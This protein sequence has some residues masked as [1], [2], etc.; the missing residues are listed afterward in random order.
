MTSGPDAAPHDPRQ[1]LDTTPPTPPPP[2]DRLA[3]FSTDKSVLVLSAL[4]VGIGVVAAFVAYALLWLLAVFTNLAY[5]QRF[6]STFT[7]PSGN[8]L[9]AWAILVPA[10]GGLLIGLMAR[11]GSEMIRGH[12]IPEALEAILIGGS[13]VQP[14]VA[15]LKPLSSGLS[16]GTGGPIIMTGGALV[17]L[18]AQRV[19]LSSAERKTLLVAGAAAGMAAIFASPM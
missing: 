7:S 14:K 6:S 3:D 17:S 16:I 2:H 18:V 10:V 4:A 1:T 19:H 11:Y 12:G 13:R 15:V 5:F 8:H 9:G